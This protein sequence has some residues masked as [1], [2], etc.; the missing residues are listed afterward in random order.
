MSEITAR[1]INSTLLSSAV[2]CAI[3]LAALCPV[4]SAGQYTVASC[5]SAA[6]FGHNTTAWVPFANAGT[7]YEACPTNGGPTAGVSNRLT[8]GTYGGF[9]HSGHAFTAPPGATITGIR[10][11]G[12]MA[13]DNCRWGV[14]F[15]AV[16]S[17]A[18][19]FGMPNGQF[20]ETLG[21]DNRGWPTP[22]AVPGGT[23]RLEQLVICG[24]AECPPPA[25]F[26]SHV[27]EVTVDDPQPPSISL[28]G[29][30]ASGQWVSGTAGTPSHVDI[31]ATD[32]AGVQRIDAALG[33]S[34]PTQSYGCNWSQP[35]P[36]VGQ[37][38]MTAAPGVGGL[39]D[40]RH[41]LSVSATDAAGNVG[42]ASRDVY[43]DNVPPDPVVP[44]IL[45]GNAWRRING[46]VVSWTN[47]PSFAAPIT[48]AH[49]K[50]CRTDG[51][52]PS[53]GQL[54]GAGVHEI[55]RLLA[56][57]PGDYRLFV[58]LEDAAGNQREATAALSVPVRFDPEPPELAF[59]AP[60]PADPLRV[61]VNGSD[62]HSG[63]AH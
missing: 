20:C 10:W 9:S 47:S 25:V 23:T 4:A 32:N 41:T 17:G 33:A 39:P 14:Y 11:A 16:P 8:Q 58:W 50:L 56:P 59:V 44:Q 30:L 35:Q 42:V 52:C 54:A 55:P 19:A 27:I 5:D 63:N 18:A 46:F 3:A 13:R 15:R 6:A 51:S 49:W 62:R 34:N 38:N 53:R 12:R 1:R 28:S 60:E 61:V 36:C 29:P 21:F 45:G 31:H 22:L 57:A 48:R 37:A 40:G 24:A 2:V 43:V 26:H 7:A